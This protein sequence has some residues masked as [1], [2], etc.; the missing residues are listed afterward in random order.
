[1]AALIVG[2]EPLLIGRIEGGLGERGRG[3]GAGRGTTAGGVGAGDPIGEPRG[4]PRGES[5]VTCSGGRFA[6]GVPVV[7]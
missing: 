7:G 4:A 5:L 2:L 6:G 3:R 1:M